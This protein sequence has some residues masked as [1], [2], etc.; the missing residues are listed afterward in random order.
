M[1]VSDPSEHARCRLIHCRA[2]RSDRSAPSLNLT[3]DKFNEVFR[4]SLL[5]SRDLFANCRETFAHRRRIQSF[6]D[7]LIES[8]DDRIRRVL[9]QEDRL[10]GGYVE[11]QAL[12]ARGWHLRQRRSA[13]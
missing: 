1:S 8:L 9:G 2:A 10:P 5:R 4:A 3:R 11:W 6:A 7:D 12:F 13:L